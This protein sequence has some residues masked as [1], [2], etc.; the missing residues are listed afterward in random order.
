MH[1]SVDVQDFQT[2][3]M[4][5]AEDTFL[6]A[7]TLLKSRISYGLRFRLQKN[8]VKK[9]RKQKIYLRK[10]IEPVE[11]K[12]DFAFFLALTLQLSIL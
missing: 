9:N 11:D 6:N 12:D 8:D 1:Q 7:D 10:K 2:G 5:G 4:V 3:E